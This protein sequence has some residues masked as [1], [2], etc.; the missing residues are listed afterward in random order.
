MMKNC[1]G[2]NLTMAISR[3]SHWLNMKF[4]NRIYRYTIV[5]QVRIMIISAIHIFLSNRMA[6]CCGFHHPHLKR[7]VI[8]IYAIG[9]LIHINALYC[10]DRGFTMVKV[11][12]CKLTNKLFIFIKIFLCRS[13]RRDRF[14]T[15]RADLEV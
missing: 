15:G 8:P 4:G 14:R 10:S 6:L 13:M 3:E 12:D 9:H 1:D 7:S 2:M 11:I 5:R